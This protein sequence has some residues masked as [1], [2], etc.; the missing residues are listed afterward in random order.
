MKRALPVGVRKSS[1]FPSVT[2]ISRRLCRS[3]RLSRTT[4]Y[5]GERKSGAFP[6]TERQSRLRGTWNH[7]TTQERGHRGAEP[8]AEIIDP[9]YSLIL[10][11]PLKTLPS[12]CVYISLKVGS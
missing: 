4:V 7:A 8:I 1:A 5:V 6:H 12:V 11:P 3:G 9:F 10:I 2:F